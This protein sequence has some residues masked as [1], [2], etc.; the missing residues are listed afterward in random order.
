MM[1]VFLSILNTNGIPF[2]SENRKENCPHDHIP[3]NVKRNVNIVF[4]DVLGRGGSSGSFPRQVWDP[5]AGQLLHLVVLFLPTSGL[6]R[7]AI[8]A[9]FCYN[10]IKSKSSL[11]FSVYHISIMYMF[12]VLGVSF[13][14]F[15]MMSSLFVDSTTGCCMN[16]RRRD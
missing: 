6:T 1:T 12:P 8:L 3:F 13:S 15:M 5:G 2:G 4:S 11:Q 7:T 14:T 10:G 16:S 9:I